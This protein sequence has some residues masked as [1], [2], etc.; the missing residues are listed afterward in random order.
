M[1]FMKKSLFIGLL[2]LF[3]IG[4]GFTNAQP[5]KPKKIDTKKVAKTMEVGMKGYEYFLKGINSGDWKEFFAMMTD[6]FT[7]FFPR[8]EF[9]GETKGKEKAMKFFKYVS[10]TFDK[11]FKVVEVLR[12]T[13][14]ETTII[15]ELRDEALLR[16]NPYKNRVAISWD[17]RGDK[18]AAYREYFGS[19]GKSN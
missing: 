13:A 17:I 9:Q 14:N 12:I 7:V 10:D 18:I 5:P 16:G 19:D 6:D 15:F 4:V 2:S 11:S 1:N 3:F 8:G